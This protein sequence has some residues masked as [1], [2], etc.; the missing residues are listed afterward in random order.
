MTRHEF[1]AKVEAAQNN[2]LNRLFDSVDS[3]TARGN[4]AMLVDMH[5]IRVLTR[6][7]CELEDRLDREWAWAIDRKEFCDRMEAYK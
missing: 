4:T 1:K 7:V 5:L 2:E 3:A 6:Y